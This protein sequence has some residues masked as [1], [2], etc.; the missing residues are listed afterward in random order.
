MKVLFEE[1]DKCRGKGSLQSLVELNVAS[2]WM[3]G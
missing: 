3:L 2:I 1:M